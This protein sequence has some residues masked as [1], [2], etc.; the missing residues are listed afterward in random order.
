MVVHEQGAQRRREEARGAPVGRGGERRREG[1]GGREA[2]RRGPAALR[3]AG[4]R[5]LHSNGLYA[6]ACV[7]SRGGE[8][9][10]VWVPTPPQPWVGGRRTLGPENREVPSGTSG[11]ASKVLGTPRWA[12][13]GAGR[14]RPGRALSQRGTREPGPR[15]PARL[16]RSQGPG[17]S[18][19]R[20]GRCVFGATQRGA[21]RG[22]AGRTRAGRPLLHPG[23]AGAP[24][25]ARRT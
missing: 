16:L 1:Q 11:L 22:A 5:P 13:G 18:R 2:W 24:A 10:C 17:T 14:T 6:R 15:C 9:V 12:R 19:E 21:S 25:R 23:P 8:C 3:L 20:R 4:N 7:C